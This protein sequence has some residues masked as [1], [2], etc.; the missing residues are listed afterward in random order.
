[1]DP[2]AELVAREEIKKR[3][4]TYCQSIDQGDWL[5]LRSCFGEEHVHNHGS[6]SGSVD[7]FVEHARRNLQPFSACQHTLSNLVV[8]FDDDG[9][10]ARSEV[11][12][13]AIHSMDGSK[14]K[15]TRFEP[16]DLGQGIDWFVAGVYRD[17]WVLRDG[18]WL[19]IERNA[20]HLWEKIEPKTPKP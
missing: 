14:S 2:L 9:R 6:Y 4:Y 17:Q 1:M 7:G 11:Y 12:F 13:N 16:K 10:S 8:D 18:H 5:T 20:S 15:G 3:L 19:I